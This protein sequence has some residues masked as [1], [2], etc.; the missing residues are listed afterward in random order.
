[1]DKVVIFG[2]FGFVSKNIVKQLNQKYQ[3]VLVDKHIDKEFAD[4]YRI[5]AIQKDIL[6]DNIKDVLEEI[7]PKYIINTISIVNADRNIDFI[8]RMI[9]INL[10][11]LLNIYE[12]SKS[13]SSLKQTIHFGS[14]E[15]YGPIEQPFSENM[16]E[17]P[18]SPY[19]LSKQIATNTAIMLH[20][21]Y[22]YPI[23]VVRP[24]NIY[25]EGQPKEKF[26]PYIV[27]NLKRNIQLNLT[28]CEQ[29]RDFIYIDKFVELL[30]QIIVNSDRALGQIVNIASG[31]SIGLKQIVEF[32]HKQLRSKSIIHFGATPYRP[33]E[34]M[35]FV[36]DTTLLKNIIGQVQ[37]IDFWA[38]FTTYLN[39]Q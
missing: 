31:Y 13:L 6:V 2:G 28:P 5:L 21:N 26:I 39:K 16:R 24:S 17:R 14:A 1:M 20:S 25:G 36:C 33:S 11:I 37:E 15:E 10:Q 18:M 29:K 9:E 32:A 12:G 7:Q 30:D 23:T 34:M 19:A 27:N 8:K 3:I 35:D 4:R 22:N 38:D